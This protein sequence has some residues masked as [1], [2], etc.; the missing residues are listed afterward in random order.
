M[1][2]QEEITLQGKVRLLSGNKSSD[3]NEWKND[4]RWFLHLYVCLCAQEADGVS[5]SGDQVAETAT[6]QIP[7]TFFLAAECFSSSECVCETSVS[8]W[9]WVCVM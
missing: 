3:T 7:H 6:Q 2:E 4:H 5:L 9:F 1:W 8:L